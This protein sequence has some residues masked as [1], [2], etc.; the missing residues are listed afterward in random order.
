M[1]QLFKM[2]KCQ[3]FCNFNCFVFRPESHKIHNSMSTLW[4]SDVQDHVMLTKQNKKVLNL[5]L[6]LW[7]I[8]HISYSCCSIVCAYALIKYLQKFPQV[9]T[10]V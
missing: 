2:L 6:W 3:C 5:V 8:I 4:L 7:Y 9:W 10:T 1:Q